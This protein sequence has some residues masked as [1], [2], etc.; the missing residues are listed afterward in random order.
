EH[1][2]L[3]LRMIV[4]IALNGLIARCTSGVFPMRHAQER[5][6]AMQWRENR[7]PM[8]LSEDALEGG[9]PGQ[10]VTI[11]P[12]QSVSSARLVTKETQL[13]KLMARALHIRDVWCSCLVELNRSSAGA[14]GIPIGEQ[15]DE[16]EH[17]EHGGEASG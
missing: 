4:D 6:A 2:R 12:K 17:D 9:P 16:G 3:D 1:D 7:F 11:A 10:H 14:A 8:A 5:R 13:L 15:A